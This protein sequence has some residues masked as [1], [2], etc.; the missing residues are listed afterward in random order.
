MQLNA[1][2][3]PEG[4][5]EVRQAFSYTLDR[6][7]THA[8]AGPLWQDYL[9]FLKGPM[10]GSPQYMAMYSTPGVPAGQ[11]ESHRA[12]VLRCACGTSHDEVRL[13]GGFSWHQWPAVALLHLLEDL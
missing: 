7:G 2:K 1:T 9:A 10:P 5:K 11:E 13:N 6:M 3:G 8:Q 4:I 12:T